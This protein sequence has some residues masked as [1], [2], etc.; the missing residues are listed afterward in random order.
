MK[1]KPNIIF[2]LSDDQGAWALECAGNHDIK[3]PNLNKLAQK[4]IRFDEFYC[5][6][7][8]CSPARASIVTGKIPSCHGVQDWIAKGNLDSK[9]YSQMA[10]LPDGMQ[11]DVPIDYLEGNKTYMEILADNGYNCALSGK[12]HLGDNVTKKKGFEQ[13]YSL[14]R[15]GCHYYAADLFEDEKLNISK[16]YVT[17]LITEK[18]LSYLDDMSKKEAPFYLSV[19]YTAPHSPWNKEEHPEEYRAIYEECKFEATPQLPVHKNQINTCPVGDTPEKRKEYLQGYYAAITAMDYGIGRILEKIER[20]GIE[21]DTIVIFTSDN[22]MNMGHHGVWGK[23]NGTYP[24]NMY[25]SSIK[26]PFIIYVPDNV[27]AGKV[28]HNRASQYDIF[29][30]ILEL[31]GCNYEKEP[32]Q[33]GESIVKMLKAPEEKFSNRIVAYDEYGETRMIKKNQYKYIQRCQED[34]CEFYDLERDPEETY[35][36]Y[37]KSQYTEIICDMK[38]EMEEWFTKYSEEL[39]DGRK[40]KVT[41]RG[42]MDFC[43]KDKA[44]NQDIKFYYSTSI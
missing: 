13:W 2:I 42:Q 12:W 7:P 8:V 25:D 4:G 5:T 14:G 15:G 31:A 16:K 1:N 26:V 19:H 34:F 44:F 11:E 39:L 27:Q 22:G 6:S 28:C 18:A 32:K 30:T 20:E 36:L 38:K 17:D 21:Q 35:N 23:G 9:K 3:T 41:G 37:N 24:P 43:Y 10:E 40:S 33:P 29:P